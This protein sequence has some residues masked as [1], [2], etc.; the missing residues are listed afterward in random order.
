LGGRQDVKSAAA[1]D[2][3][4]ER[5]NWRNIAITLI[6]LG[7]DQALRSFGNLPTASVIASPEI[8]P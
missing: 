2:G 5:Y 7:C 6:D 1:I 8:L 4:D 3:G